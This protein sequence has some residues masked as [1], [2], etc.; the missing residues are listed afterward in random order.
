[1][2]NATKALIMA[3]AILIVILIISVGLVV[4]RSTKGVTEA[5]QEGADL[6]AIETYNS[7]FTKYCGDRVKGSTVKDLINYV[8]TYNARNASNPGP[9]LTGTVSGIRPAS[10][11]SVTITGR[12]TTGDNAGRVTEITISGPIN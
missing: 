8:A 6:A 4:F 5:G 2:E 1:M 3:G 12:Q 7:Q 10:E 9:T 11:Y